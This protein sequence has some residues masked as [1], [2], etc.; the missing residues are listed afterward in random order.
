MRNKFSYWKQKHGWKWRLN[1]LSP[2]NPRKAPF[3]KRRLKNYARE[4]I[5]SSTSIISSYLLLWTKHFK[6]IE[7]LDHPDFDQS[8]KISMFSE[9]TLLHSGRNCRFPI[10]IT[11]P[12]RLNII[13][14]KGRR[15]RATFS[16]RNK[17]LNQTDT[18]YPTFTSAAACFILD[19]DEDTPSSESRVSRFSRDR[20]LELKA[21]QKHPP[22]VC[23]AR[24]HECKITCRKK[25]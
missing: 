14:R 25:K 11:S 19:E 3:S 13:K 24:V 20:E 21:K 9:P 2:S 18:C 16:R 5:F 23:T 1:G 8:S 6:N 15:E 12:S 4:R 22:I 17:R 7:I 10:A